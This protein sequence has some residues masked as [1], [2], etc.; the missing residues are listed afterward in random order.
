M[1][2]VGRDAVGQPLIVEECADFASKHVRS[3]GATSMLL[4]LTGA[5]P[6]CR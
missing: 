2:R 4:P 3:A 6:N 1:K 5:I